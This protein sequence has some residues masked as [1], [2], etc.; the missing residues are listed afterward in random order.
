MYRHHAFRP[1]ASA[2]S[3]HIDPFQEQTTQTII[4]GCI[5]IMHSDHQPVLNHHTLILLFKHST[6]TRRSSQSDVRSN[7]RTKLH[8]EIGTFATVVWIRNGQIFQSRI[9]FSL[10]IS[11]LN[12]FP[13][14][15]V[16]KFQEWVPVREKCDQSWF[17]YKSVWS[18]M[19][20]YSGFSR[21]C[22]L[23]MPGSMPTNSYLCN[24]HH[25]CFTSFRVKQKMNG[26]CWRVTA[27]CGRTQSS[28]SPLAYV[29]CWL[30]VKTPMRC[31][32]VYANG[33]QLRR[34]T[35]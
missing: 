17:G 35:A 13:N 15:N 4:I 27:A 31:F 26:I 20:M 32:V 18:L 16:Q 33:E 19:T 28:A 29:D 24:K 34:T 3:P 21:N 22:T 25:T 30:Y 1:P 5:D 12:Y 14:G 2:E 7:T 10:P 8:F 23:Y 9:Y 11:M 6:H